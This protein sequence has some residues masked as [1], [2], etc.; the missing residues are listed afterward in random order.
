M[1]RRWAAIYFA[2][3]LVMAA[4]AY[5]VMAVAEEP[6]MNIDGETYEAGDTFEVDGITYTVSEF[7]EREGELT[8]TQTVSQQT[9]FQNNSVVEYRNGSYNVSIEPADD[10]ETFT[11]AQEFDVETILQND[12]EVDNTTYTSDDGTEFVRYKNGSTEPLE[13]YLP[14]P[15]RETF[16]EGDQIDHEDT[17]KAVDN[18][19]SS[20]ATLTW[21][22]ETE[23]S[24][25]LEEGDRITLGGTEYVVTFVD[26]DTV[27]LSTD[28]EGYEQTLENREYFQERM[29]GLLFVILFSLGSGFLVAGLALLPHRG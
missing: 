20:A 17:T 23:Q 11:L 19:T 18:V 12:P 16:S 3:F 25:G 26:D 7:E 22:Q 2:F 27:R 13:E 29:S 4:S 14:E 15:N 28:I 8:Y 10:P 9:T 6:T 21:E 5:S 24:I 1:Q